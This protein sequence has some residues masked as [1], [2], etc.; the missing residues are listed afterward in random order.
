MLESLFRRFL[1]DLIVASEFQKITATH[2]RGLEGVREGERE[3]G[4]KIGKIER[5]I[6]SN[7]ILR[8]LLGG[9]KL[10]E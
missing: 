3:G 2:N 4:V 8:P 5:Y 6:F 7:A 9:K 10:D 1:Y